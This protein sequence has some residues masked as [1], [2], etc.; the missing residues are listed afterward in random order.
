MSYASVTII[1]LNGKPVSSEL[2]QSHLEE[3]WEN[4][5][6]DNNI[7]YTEKLIYLKTER[8]NAKKLWVALRWALNYIS[9]AKRVRR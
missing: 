2:D 3:P 4:Y 1:Y 6:G 5:G 8:E 7:G 9:R